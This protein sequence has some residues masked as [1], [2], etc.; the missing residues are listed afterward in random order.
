MAERVNVRMI[1]QPDCCGKPMGIDHFERTE[2]SEALW[3]PTWECRA[4]GGTRET[5]PLAINPVLQ[6]LLEHGRDCVRLGMVA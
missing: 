1:G 5:P 4:C 3:L 6:R 2:P